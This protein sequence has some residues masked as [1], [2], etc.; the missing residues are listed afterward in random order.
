MNLLVCNRNCVV[1]I[2]PKLTIPSI[3]AA[4]RIRKNEKTTQMPQISLSR[5]VLLAIVSVTVLFTHLGSARLWDRDEPRNARASHEML[6]RGDWIVPTFNGEL[7]VHKPILLYWGQMLSYLT[8]GESEFSARLPS[9]LAAILS[10]VSVA[11]LASRLSGGQSGINRDGYWAAGALATSLLFVMAGRAATPDACLIGFS[12]AGIAALV[13]SA[14]APAQPFSSGHVRAARWIPAAFGYTMI[15]LAVLAKGPVGLVLPLAIVH[16]WWLICYQLQTRPDVLPAKTEVQERSFAAMLL[17]L[18]AEAWTTFHPWRCIRVLIALR[19]IPGILL[20]LLAAAPW[21]VAVGMETDGAFLRGF[22]LE[23]NLGRAVNSMEGHGGS[24]F[25]YPVAFLVGTFPW[26]LWL[27]PIA[28]CA[29]KAY[30][31]N[32]VNRQMVVLASVWIA[33]YIVAFTMASTKLPSYITPCYAGAALLIG[34]YWRQF[35]SSWSMPTIAWRRAG[36]LLSMGVGCC[37]A[38]ALVWLSSHESMPALV[39]PALC[40]LV[41]AAVGLLGFAWEYR[42]QVSYV[43]ATWLIGAAAFQT[44]LFGFGAK[45]V[46]SYRHD[47]QLLTSIQQENPNQHWMSIGGMEPSWV[48]Y[49]DTMIAEVKTPSASETTWESA[50]N[51]LEHYPDGN[52]IV[53]GDDAHRALA[54]QTSLPVLQE[55]DTSKRFLRPGDVRVFRRVR[56]VATGQATRQER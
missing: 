43:P 34:S 5:L 49:L 35:E 42:N 6:A 3:A 11:V 17:R 29:R 50:R 20:T 18:L 31:D 7:R 21:Y 2:V 47:L 1:T 41:I 55:V 15:G 45:T 14:L 51:F 38:I 37:I 28:A 27:I 23:H 39:R 53:V 9:A 10:I 54:M 22:F 48:H 19:T 24:L 44:V 13:T 36:Y 26:S 16:I 30:R 32:V 12:T 25:F 4:E 40:G 33:V 8:F 56:Q 52:I 46:D